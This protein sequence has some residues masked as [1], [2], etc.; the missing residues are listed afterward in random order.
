MNFNIFV[1]YVLT[2]ITLFFAVITSSCT[3]SQPVETQQTNKNTAVRTESIQTSF[4][5][6]GIQGETALSLLKSKY[7]VQTKDYGADLGE[8]VLAINGVEPA[9]DE[10]W[11]FYINGKSANVGASSYTTQDGDT[12]EWKLEKITNY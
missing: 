2:V 7:T 6:T 4:S 11:A 3:V 1:R 10:F 9:K 12:I 8:M 5:Y